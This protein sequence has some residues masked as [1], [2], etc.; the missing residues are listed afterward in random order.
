MKDAGIAQRTPRTFGLRVDAVVASCNPPCR[1]G[2]GADQADPAFWRDLQNMGRPDR[3]QERFRQRLICVQQQSPA[4]PG[5]M[6]RSSVRYGSRAPSRWISFKFQLHGPSNLGTGP[7]QAK[8][9]TGLWTSKTILGSQGSCWHASAEATARQKTNSICCHVSTQALRHVSVTRTSNEHS[10]L[11]GPSIC[12]VWFFMVGCDSSSRGNSMS[13]Q[14]QNCCCGMKCSLRALLVN[15]HFCMKEMSSP[16]PSLQ[17]KDANTNVAG[18]K[19]KPTIAAK[20]YK[21][22]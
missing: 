21:K 22:H 4:D 14:V 9:D 7:P 12:Q 18:G 19:T 5:T 6:L 8:K 16:F 2:R 17:K 11:T 1:T 20:H 10:P 3:L 13:N 15:K